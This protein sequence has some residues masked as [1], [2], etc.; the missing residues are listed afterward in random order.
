[1]KQIQSLNE[2][3]LQSSP[4]G[5]AQSVKKYDLADRTLKFAGDIIEFAQILPESSVM[6]Q[7]R[8]QFV[9]S[10]TSVGANYHEANSAASR[11]DFFH[12]ISLCRKE[13][14]ETTYWLQLILKALPGQKEKCQILI[15]ESWELTRIFLSIYKQSK[16]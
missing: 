5:G 12:K 11:K 3:G 4:P 8:S 13:A 7:L 10:G 16:N 15:K 2:E 1:M 6:Y 9:R 14:N